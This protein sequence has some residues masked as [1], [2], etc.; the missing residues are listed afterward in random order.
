M[1][2]I[3]APHNCIFSMTHITAIIHNTIVLTL[4]FRAEPVLNSI[5]KHGIQKY[6]AHFSPTQLHSFTFAEN[7][8]TL[9]DIIWAVR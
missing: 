5:G 9:G 4:S 1:A 3:P 6:I 7:T 2:C 8:K